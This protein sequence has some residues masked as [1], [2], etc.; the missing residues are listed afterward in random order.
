MKRIFFALF[1]LLVLFSACHADGGIMPMPDYEDSVFMPEQKAVIIWDGSTEEMILESKIT[2]AD[3]ANFAWLIPIESSTKPVVE[4]A[5]EQVFFDLAELF[6]PK[7]K[8]LARGIFPQ[9]GTLSANGGV[10]VVEELK[11]DI[12]DI[13]ILKAT[14][15]GALIEWLNG[16]GY[17]FP[18]A[19]PNL[20]DEFVQKGN[21]YFIANKINLQNKYPGLN[22]TKQ[23]FE[24]AQAIASDPWLG[25]SFYGGVDEIA[26]RIEYT[27]MIDDPR[28]A[29]ASAEPTAV[30]VSLR[31]GIAT[32]LKITSTPSRPFYPMKLS[33]LNLG[34]GKAL[35]YF[36]SGKAFKDSTGI[37]STKNMLQFQG[38]YLSEYG[39]SNGD[40]I[41]LL[42]WQGSYSSL[43]QDSFFEET[44]FVPELDP[45]FVPLPEITAEYAVGFVLFFFF[46]FVPLAIPL[47]LIP[48]LFGMLIKWLL[49]EKK[50][51][52]SFFAKWN[53]L[54]ACAL[55]AFFAL[56]G[57]L[58]FA[59]IFSIGFLYST[60]LEEIL[61]A[62]FIF[63]FIFLPYYASMACGF[64]F[65]KTKPMLRFVLIPLAVYIAFFA[66]LL[67][68]SG[69]IFGIWPD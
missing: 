14:D 66:V 2:T 16:T 49:D 53:G 17:S 7:E 27:G 50:K 44:P 29:G 69:I 8:D 65:K 59:L 39:I 10:E 51:K 38:D 56:L 42:E 6:R 25:Q 41:T 32:P 58:Y 63:A 13:A 67:L 3:I 34:D 15:S 64:L 40:S 35:V 43:E 19:F 48:F 54:P 20:L 12:Y 18:S 47:V 11:V 68:F 28:C 45:N 26:G 57:P 55:I 5:D 46:F 33:S 36:V 30:L 23:D 31:L 52:K 62:V 9:A 60:T 22:P 21:V 37:F 1:F 61:N 24:C 4:A